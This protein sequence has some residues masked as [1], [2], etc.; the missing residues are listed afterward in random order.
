MRLALDTVYKLA[1]N[2]ELTD[3]EALGVARWLLWIQFNGGQMMDIQSMGPN[4]AVRNPG[5]ASGDSANLERPANNTCAPARKRLKLSDR[6]R[7]S[8]QLAVQ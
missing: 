8:A 4:N 6:R 1:T 2:M 7:P 3:E 5:I